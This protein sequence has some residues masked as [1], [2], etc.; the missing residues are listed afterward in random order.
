M[1]SIGI[2]N[3]NMVIKLTN[4]AIEKKRMPWGEIENY[5]GIEEEVRE[6]LP[7]TLWDTWE[8]ADGEIDRIIWDTIGKRD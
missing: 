3:R 5:Q 1:R 2:K 6:K 8:G 4:E 7:V